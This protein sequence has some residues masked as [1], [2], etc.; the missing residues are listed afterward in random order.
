MYI[1]LVLYTHTHTHRDGARKNS[2]G[3]Q[4]RGGKEKNSVIFIKIINIYKG[5][6]FSCRPQPLPPPSLRHCVYIYIY[7]YIYILN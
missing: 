3:G 1:M 4:I 2:R 6:V 5:E 7:I